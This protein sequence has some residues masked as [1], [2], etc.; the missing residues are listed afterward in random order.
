MK[1]KPRKNKLQALSL[2]ALLSMGGGIGCN[3]ADDG[4][5]PGHGGGGGKGDSSAIATFL[6]FEF[7]G[8]VDTDT[9]WNA[10]SVI[11]DQLL[12]T[13]GHLNGNNSVGRLDKV[14]IT[15]IQQGTSNG[16]TRI[17]Y[18]AK[19]PVAWGSKSDLPKTY[20]FTLPRDMSYAGKEAFTE[21]YKH[22]CVDWG[23]HDVDTGSMWYYYRPASSECRLDDADVL[24]FSAQTTLSPTNSKN[25]YPEY[26]KVWED[27]KLNA[28]LI[29]GKY[30]DGSTTD[31]DAGIA[32][33]NTFVRTAKNAFPG[34][35]TTPENV[36]DKPGI[37]V[38]DV[39]FDVDLGNGRS[40]QIVALLVDNVRTSDPHFNERY[41][42]LST[43]A[44]VI[45]Y[46]GHAG[47]GQNVRALARK[48][49]FVSGQYLIMFMNG[50]DT[51]AY[52]DG[53][54]AEA[55][56]QLNPEDTT[57]TKYL[58]IVTNAMPAFFSNMPTSSL[59][60]LRALT[61]VDQ[62]MTYEQIFG[63]IDRSQVV[64]VTG[65]EDNQYKPSSSGGGGGGALAMREEASVGRGE[66]LEFETP[67][68]PAG[69]YLVRMAQTSEHPGGDADLYV[70]A[71]SKPTDRSYDCRPY[72]DG[73]DEE[74][75][76]KLTSAQ[77]I[78]MSVKGYAEGESFFVLT[79]DPDATR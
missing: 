33:F 13:I 18:H 34:I 77:K 42:A 32:G 9:A 20:Q 19:L 10:R 11:D 36:S 67:E 1:I 23:A 48:G 26:D 72:K 47:L 43:R 70:K 22:D 44:D 8:S 16:K 28:L 25:T 21:K 75:R 61:K 66:T 73:S 59:A 55:R 64:L 37:A 40:M 2:A 52:V 60:L 29:F 74:C 58:D 35:K 76:V 65:D 62:P 71:G 45:A 30:E 51:F 5:V 68:L 79:A 24:K 50:C 41:E 78:Y 27:G 63:G 53:F 12:F 54:M 7:D 17:S 4:N 46:N 3:G 57:G 49:K 69:N 56:R 6:T 39:T 38:P 14:E 15:N 31:A